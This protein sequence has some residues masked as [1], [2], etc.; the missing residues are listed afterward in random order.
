MTIEINEKGSEAFYK[1]TVN[2]AAQYRYL[3]KNKNY[4]L[5][6]YFVQFRT[7]VIA[8]LA[9]LAVNVV[10]MILWGAETYQIAVSAALLIAALMSVAYLLSLNK[11]YKTMMADPHTSVLTLDDDGVELKVRDTQTVRIAKKNVAVI[12]TFSESLCFIPAAGAGVI[13]SVNKK[14]ADEIL[15]WVRENWPGTDAA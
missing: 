10:L 4:K 12:R 11:T 13:I 3:L 1:D 8:S 5:K 15:G 7:L 14:Y 9:V 6:D 2:A